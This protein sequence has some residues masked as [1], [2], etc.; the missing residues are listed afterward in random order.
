M[1]AAL[2]SA[3][4][5]DA[6]LAVAERVADLMARMSLDEKIAQLGGVFPR[7]FMDGDAFSGEMAAR[8]I[9]H[10][11]GHVSYPPGVTALGPR[12]LASLLNDVQHFLVEETRLGIPAVAHGESAGGYTGRGGT[13]FPQAI[14][15]ASTWEPALIE[16]MTRAIRRQMRAVG[17]RHTLSPVLDIVRD[18]RWGRCEETYGE[19][20]YLAGQMGAAYV[21][22]MQ[23]DDLLDS[24]VATG[25]HFL[26]Y[27]ASE[28]GMNWAP[29]HLGEREIREVYAAPFETA[30]REGGL[31]SIMNSYAEIDG[32]P[33]GANRRWLRDYLRGELGFDGTVISDYFT[34]STLDT[35]HHI[36]DRAECAARALEAGIDLEVPNLHYYRSLSE[37]LAA[38]RI[39]ISL[40]DEAVGRV[41]RQKFELGVF[42]QPYVDAKAAPSMLD[43]P[44]D[45]ALARRISAESIVVLKND[46]DLLPLSKD[47]RSIAIIG[48]C[49]DSIRLLQGDYHFPAHVEV[50]F[51][52]IA[53]SHEEAPSDGA[54]ALAA[55]A[56]GQAGGR[57]DLREA[58]TPHVTIRQGIREAAPSAE[59]I[60]ARG[61]DIV[62]DDMS[63]IADA[64]KAARA[65][66][67]AVVCVG[68][69]SGLVEGS[70]SGESSDRSDLSLTP[71]Q[72]QL[73]ESVVATGTPALVVL[74]GGGIVAIPWI[75]E[76][77]PAIVQAWC[78]GE[79][80]GHALA[81]VLFG[82]VNPSGRLPVSMPRAT[83][84]VPVYY[85]HKPSGGRSNWRGHYVDGPATPLFAFG[86]GLPYTTFEYGELRLS[87][88]EVPAEASLE[89]SVDITNSG[90][91]AGDEIV[92]LYVHD[93]VAS[94]TRPVQ[95][96]AGFARVSL[97]AGETR[98]IAFTL[99]T[100][101]LALYDAEMR[102]V[103]EPGTIEVMVGASSADIRSRAIFEIVG[104]VR[105]LRRADR[106]ST[107]VTLS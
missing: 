52:R 32:V 73:V 58:F 42:E 28:G 16:E 94:T 70:T 18:A 14:G 66:E 71:A 93:V 6:S 39:D 30:V 33:L 22:G 45:R 60:Y 7:S 97:R 95:Q 69:R 59:A 21:R 87:P 13:V 101:Q 29:A 37:A 62:G 84:Q 20:P 43:T 12:E 9:P 85:N 38:G 3:L 55:V 99:D 86:H 61:C 17:V 24:V 102:F 100:S 78:P 49:A 90:K 41:L 107:K 5:R 76:H 44:E 96:L 106:R 23:G 1:D 54:P 48:P 68:T 15:L 35:Y 47:I 4:Y 83:G 36:G 77:V 74:I 11:I 19:D 82:D 46:G 31:A 103:V 51:G 8:W 25:K 53:E 27:G 56:P 80:G 104:D 92:Q 105:E 89:I 79:E 88:K 10:G 57:V 50:M 40:I 34:V 63:G 67:V 75:A 2:T 72:Q 26:G 91:R 65:A 64:V 81:D 98:T